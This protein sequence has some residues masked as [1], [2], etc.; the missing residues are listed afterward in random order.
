MA[1]AHLFSPNFTPITSAHPINHFN[2]Y[3]PPVRL[4]LPRHG[5]KRDFSLLAVASTSLSPV[6]V[7]Y[8][9]RE[10]SGHGVSFVEIGES[11]VLGMGLENGSTANLM[12]PSGMITSYKAPMWHGSTLEVLHTWVSEGEQGQAVVRGGVY[13]CF[14][15]SSDGAVPWS[16][17]SWA[18]RDVRGSPRNFIQVELISGDSDDL[19]EVTYIVTLQPELL[20]SELVISNLKSLPLQLVGSVMTHLTVSTPDA[21]YAV[22]LEGSNYFSRPPFISDFS[23]VPPKFS[24]EKRPV[25]RQLSGNTALGRLL[26]SG[27]TGEREDREMEEELE[28]EENANY[29]QLT[30]KMSRVYTSAPRRFTI[31]DR[32][33][34]NSVIV[35]REGFDEMYMFSPGSKYEWYSKYAYICTGASAVLKPIIVDPKDVWSGGQYLHNPNL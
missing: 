1:N 34:R 7:G 6:N 28:G 21:T 12:L 35:G 33:R 9:K 16:P 11:C 17:S 27:R 15:C 5:E 30:E 22:G 20:S 32:G 19:I 18:L 25:S 10:F 3:P 24:Q 31:V 4:S 14:K 26:S 8:L 2:F 23:I 29:A 13:P